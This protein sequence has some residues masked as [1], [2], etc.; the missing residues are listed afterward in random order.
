MRSR[1]AI[2]LGV[3][4]AIVA[5]DQVTKTVALHAL[6]PGRSVSA[7][8]GILHWTLQRNP[9]AAFGL[10]QRI[11]VLFTILAIAIAVAILATMGRSRD[12]PTA[13]AMGLVLGGALGNLADRLFRPPGPFRGRVIDFIDFRVWPTFNLADAAVVCGAVL[14]AI[15]S[16]RAPQ[17]S[18]SR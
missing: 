7:I 3:A 6:V 1:A 2:V 13:V 15:A 18:A 11:P 4:A 8:D 10:F 12:L 16:L 17:R 9:G 14:L 5:G